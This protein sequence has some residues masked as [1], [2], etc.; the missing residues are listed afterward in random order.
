MPWGIKTIK[1]R[2]KL[3]QLCV[4][5][6]IYSKHSFAVDY[7]DPSLLTTAGSNTK[8]S[9]D[10]SYFENFGSNA[11]GDYLVDIYIND[12]FWETRNVK[13]YKNNN[14][15][16]VPGL[17]LG[18]LNDMGVNITSLGNVKKMTAN[19]SVDNLSD[20]IQGAS[21]R[22]EQSKLRLNISVPQIYMK[23]NTAD[24]MEP[25]R[26]Q[27]G[28]NAF[29]LNY[30]FNGN[31]SKQQENNH[32]PQQNQNAMFASFNAGL[33]FGA[34]RVRS[35]STWVHS[36]L[37]QDQY[38]TV[39]DQT[40]KTGTTQ[41]KWNFLN[42][43]LQR[44]VQSLRGELTMGDTATGNVASQVFDG[45]PYRGV[46]LASNMLMTPDNL[47]GFAPVIS[48]IADSNAKV[49][50]SQ[51]GTVIFQSYVPPGPFKFNN[52]DNVANTGDLKVTITEADGR[53][54]GYRVPASSVPVMQ[55]EGALLYEYDAGRYH[56]SG[57]YTDGADEKPFALVS[58]IYGM[59]HGIT[60]Y[61]GGLAAQNYQSAAI[62]TAVGIGDIGAIS[63]D[64]TVS[65]TTLVGDHG[66]ETGRSYRAQYAKSVLATGTTLNLTA[67]RYSTSRFYNFQDANTVGY[68]LASGQKP[69]LLSRPRASWQVSVNQSAGS[70]GSFNLSALRTEYWRGEKTDNT[71]SAGFNSN[72]LGVNW[73]VNYSIDHIRGSGD[74]PQNRQISFNV[75]VPFRLFSANQG[76]SNISSTFYMTH[77]ST[78]RTTTQTGLN[79]S[80]GSSASWYATQGR[81]NQGQ[82]ISS[83]AGVGYNGSIGQSS[84]GYYYN[85]QRY[86][87]INYSVSGGLLVHRY[88]VTLT[89]AINDSAILV[90]AVGAP[91]VAVLNG[92]NIK[93]NHWGYAVVPNISPYRR[94]VISLDPST[95]PDGVDLSDTSENIW[96]TQGAVVLADYPVRIG[97]Q[98]LVN[99]IYHDKPVPFGAIVVLNSD[100]KQDNSFI[101][102]DEGQVYLNALPEQGKLNVSWGHAADQHCI[103]TF[104]IGKPPAAENNNHTSIKQLTAV[105]R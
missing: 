5:I 100:D 97:Q 37:T 11:P 98:A 91:G 16:V 54:H 47:L 12:N 62:G 42:T 57:G 1:N 59:P 50:V 64:T 55:R 24:N 79:G 39:A 101:V 21:A 63:L 69:W 92:S 25:G 41:D 77:D 29:L 93:T 8:L 10:L 75:S 86:H 67:Y 56:Q 58:L 104:S 70:I 84:L 105:C 87:S 26:W 74:W 94:N 78:G 43:Y 85:N 61:G 99:L 82:D 88:G 20:L 19:E 76:V 22:F 83:S 68:H 103:A 96:P 46:S 89:P 36:H 2:I 65:R 40:R 45:F 95:L 102:G 23:Y 27:Q 73:A 35:N 6:I 7:F 31:N 17:T 38:D 13:F 51:N 9:V 48:G 34:W 80:L 66:T 4:F 52:I 60:L 72:I 28:I 90:R 44:D 30:S 81:G 15:N 33:N 18:M 53:T 71:L 14:N 32:T 49:S 3:K